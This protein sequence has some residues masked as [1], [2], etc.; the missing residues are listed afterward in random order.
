MSPASVSKSIAQ[1]EA[2][3]GLRLFNRTTRKVSLTDAGQLLFERSGALLELIDLTQG[4]L[5]Q[6]A[7]RPGRGC[8]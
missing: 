5:L 6:R 4:E 2:R 7:T 1:L 3:F 8:S